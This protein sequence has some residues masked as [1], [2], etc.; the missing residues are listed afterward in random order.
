ME[1][2]PQMQNKSLASDSLIQSLDFMLSPMTLDFV[3]ALRAL[4]NAGLQ[5]SLLRP[6]E[7]PQLAALATVVLRV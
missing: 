6:Q 5:R 2:A 1:S 7:S 3:S 4:E